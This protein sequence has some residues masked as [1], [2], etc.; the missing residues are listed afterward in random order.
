MT[1]RLPCPV[2]S[3]EAQHLDA[4]AA[5]EALEEL[6]DGLHENLNRAIAADP[7]DKFQDFL[8]WLADQDSMHA[9][10]G[11]LLKSGDSFT[12]T[13]ALMRE[14]IGAWRDAEVAKQVDK[15]NSEPI[16]GGMF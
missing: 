14:A 8:C 15:L 3:A 7:A 6:E 2:A 16:N 10:L 11:A 9:E 4:L 5:G 13:G 12:Q 1:A